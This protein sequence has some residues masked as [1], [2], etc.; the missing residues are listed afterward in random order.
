M[1]NAISFV[2]SVYLFSKSLEWINRALLE[3]TN[4]PRTIMMVNG[5]SLVFS[6]SMM[7]YYAN[8]Q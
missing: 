4:L 1:M 7:V 2:G 3:K 6:G 5:L 8:R